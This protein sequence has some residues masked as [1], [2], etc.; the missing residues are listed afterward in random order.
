[1]SSFILLEKVN[2]VL[3]LKNVYEWI[4]AE[5]LSAALI[6]G[7]WYPVMSHMQSKSLSG[8][9]KEVT[10]GGEQANSNLGNTINESYYENLQC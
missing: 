4:H 1:M 5:F 3:K 8:S 2:R 9:F 6:A 7:S 10:F